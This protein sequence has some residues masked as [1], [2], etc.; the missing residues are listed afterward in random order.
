MLTLGDTCLIA[1]AGEEF[2]VGLLACTKV[3]AAFLP[4]VSLAVGEAL[5]VPLLGEA[6]SADGAAVDLL[7]DGSCCLT[8]VDVA[9]GAAVTR[10][11]ESAVTAAW[12][13]REVLSGVSFSLY[14]TYDGMG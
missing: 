2:V 8:G 12:S 11:M 14:C 7:G 10:G 9:I 4:G 5:T 6:I 3:T 13:G 1:G